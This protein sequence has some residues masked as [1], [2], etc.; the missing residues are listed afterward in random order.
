M[1]AKATRQA[2]A[3]APEMTV[4]REVG[5]YTAFGY[6]SVRVANRD[7][8]VPSSGGGMAHEFSREKLQAQSREFMRDNGIYAGMIRRAASFI[9]GEGFKLQCLSGSS[10][11]N[12][13][14]EERFADFFRSP[15]LTG[16]K[17]GAQCESMVTT[18]LLVCGE[19]LVV[20]TDR[21]KIQLVEAEQL[22]P[23]SGATRGDD[24]IER[25]S[26]GAPTSYRIVP[27][28]ANGGFDNA[29]ARSVLADSVL[30]LSSPD[31]PSSSRAVPPCQASFSIL[32]CINDVAF[33]EAVA[34]QMQ[35]KLA[36]AVTR[37]DG[38]PEADDVS[39]ED[40]GVPDSE[41]EG[42]PSG[43][44]VTQLAIAT[45]FHGAPGEEIRGIER[46]APAKNFEATLAMFFRLMGLPLGLPL[47]LT[48]LD[49]TKSN[50][51]QSRAVLEQAKVSFLGWQDLLEQRFYRRIFLWWLENEIRA[52]RIKDR[53]DKAKHE[54]VRPAAPWLDQLAEA[55][56]HGENCDRGFETFDGVCKSRNTDAE[57]QRGKLAEEARAA[58]TVARDLKTEFPEF[59]FPW[60]G[61]AGRKAPE[62]KPVPAEGSKPKPKTGEP[63]KKPEPE[64]I[65][66][67]GAA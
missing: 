46:T 18:E 64:K 61:F 32:H 38:Y 47:E 22:R 63:E 25:D 30:Y 39:K 21:G 16:L 23:A 5:F 33:S 20:L 34:W 3:A 15:E 52:G 19:H 31:R 26:D 40:A 11:W 53:A 50:Y 1:I 51:S 2:R 55:Q 29:K 13:D 58:A 66:A 7:G 56:A 59:E 60:Q 42:S 36:L 14:V 27:Y 6:R 62:P 67:G 12:K 28:D 10:K 49:W 35:S 65:P 17:S 4:D 8:R 43:N 45:V 37:T 54:W 9:V 41:S 44:R 48:L 24:G 57:T